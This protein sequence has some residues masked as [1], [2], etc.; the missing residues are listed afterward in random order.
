MGKTQQMKDN[1]EKELKKYYHDISKALPRERK[2]EFLAD[3]KKSVNSYLANNPEATIDDVITF[4]GNPKDIADEFYANETGEKITKELKFGKKIVFGVIIV[5]ILAFIIYIIAI[6]KIVIMA[7][8]TDDGY[9]TI[10]ISELTSNTD[11]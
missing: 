9:Y 7:E 11:V 5:L 1:F 2:K 4:I 10:E 6:A 8:K 3:I